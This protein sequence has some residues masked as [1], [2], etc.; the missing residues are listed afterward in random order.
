MVVC[1]ENDADGV[2]AGVV[3]TTV[4]NSRSLDIGLIAFRKDLRTSLMLDQLMLCQF[5]TL[6]L[7]QHPNNSYY[8]R[9]KAVLFDNASAIFATEVAARSD[10]MKVD[11]SI[12]AYLK[13]PVGD[14]SGITLR[15]FV[16]GIQG[17]I[18]SGSFRNNMAGFRASTET[19]VS[20]SDS[21]SF[22][23]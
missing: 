2:L 21:N 17:D 11:A 16:L 9:Q 4:G 1:R 23:S 22:F 8:A 5:S 6:S 13:D 10:M 12:L 20:V 14:G 18:I 3:S 7:V 19:M 15:E